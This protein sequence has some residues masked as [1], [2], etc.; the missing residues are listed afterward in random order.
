MHILSYSI[1]GIHAASNEFGEIEK[2]CDVIRLLLV[3]IHLP[4]NGS[5][6]NAKD[7]RL[8]FE[9]VPQFHANWTIQ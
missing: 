1:P 4:I 9:L 6:E 2:R 3:Y 5:I 8:P 7:D